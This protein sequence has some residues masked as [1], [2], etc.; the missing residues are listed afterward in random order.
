MERIMKKNGQVAIIVLLVSAIMLTMGLTMSKKEVTEIKINS[1]DE[2]LKKAFDTAESGIDYYLGTGGVN[3]VSP[4]NNSVASI[5]ATTIGVGQTINFGEYTTAGGS[6]NYWLVDHLTDG[7]MGINYF[8]GSSVDVCGTSFT[9]KVEVSVFSRTAL[10]RNLIDVA[11]NCVTV[12][13]VVASPVLLTV[14]PLSGGG[15]FYIQ[16]PG[17][18]SFVSQGIDI[19]SQGSA[20]GTNKKLTI[21]QRFRLPGFLTSGMMAEGSVRSD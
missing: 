8:T 11:N 19:V 2:L 20:G 21:R 1:N 14:T 4:D 10:K 9:G 12:D 17:G 16:A 3:Y 18:A 13:T 7:S 5:N 6:E 15:K